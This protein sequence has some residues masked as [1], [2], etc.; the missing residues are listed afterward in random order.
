MP[1]ITSINIENTEN[2]I[3]EKNIM[4]RNKRRISKR[5]KERI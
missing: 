4:N 1:M 3:K 5:N 2:K